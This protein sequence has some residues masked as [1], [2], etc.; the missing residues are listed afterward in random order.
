MKIR[1]NRQLEIHWKQTRIPRSSPIEIIKKSILM[2]KIFLF[3]CLENSSMINRGERMYIL[4][5]LSNVRRKMNHQIEF[6]CI[7]IKEFLLNWFDFS[8]GFV[9][10]SRLLNH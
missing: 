10:F 4:S 7:Q 6:I 2:K 8:H 1:F 9:F 5:F 3:Y